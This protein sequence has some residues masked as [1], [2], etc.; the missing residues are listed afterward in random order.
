MLKGDLDG[1]GDQVSSIVHKQ[2]NLTFVQIQDLM[3][4]CWGGCTDKGWFYHENSGSSTNP[5]FSSTATTSGT[6][7]TAL[8]NAVKLRGGHAVIMLA[9]MDQGSMHPID[10]NLLPEPPLHQMGISTLVAY[11]LI[12]NLE[13]D[14]GR[15]QVSP[16]AST[17]RDE[18][19]TRESEGLKRESDKK[20]DKQTKNRRVRERTQE[21]TALVSA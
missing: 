4:A 6:V 15:T 20:R 1:D 7:F 3:I 10:I 19:R 5:V 14:I 11:L 18:R 17:E 2:A 12:S 21:R 16:I 13:W 8:Q 9:D